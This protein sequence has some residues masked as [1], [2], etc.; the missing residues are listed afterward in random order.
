MI[1]A[2]RLPEP[3]SYYRRL[4][5]FC[6]DWGFNAIL[7][8]LADDQGSAFRFTS[9][10]E[11]ITHPHA[12]TAQELSCLSG[13]AASRGIDLI[14]EIESFGHTAYITRAPQHSHLQDSRPSGVDQFTSNDC[15]VN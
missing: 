12:F 14:P 9:H 11:L 8:R 10:P 1:D 4:I 2:A 7:F 15:L 6:A 5:D 13:Y 3:L